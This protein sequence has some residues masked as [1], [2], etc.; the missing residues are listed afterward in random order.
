[1]ISDG[2]YA[3]FECALSNDKHFVKEPIALPQCG[4]CVCK[5][6]LLNLNSNVI[7]CKKCSNLNEFKDLDNLKETNSIK[8]AIKT[9]FDNLIKVIEVQTIK[10][11]EKLKSKLIMIL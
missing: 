7:K 9:N 4:H 6:C 1:M 2:K 8:K 11:L 3:E 10:S 5:L